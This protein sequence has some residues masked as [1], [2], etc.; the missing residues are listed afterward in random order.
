MVTASWIVLSVQLHDHGTWVSISVPGYR[1][2][3]FY[4]SPSSAF[5]GLGNLFC[6]TDN[7]LLSF[8]AIKNALFGLINIPNLVHVCSHLPFNL[9]LMQ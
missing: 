3:S 6:A 8:C 7:E 9:A 1:V 5:L 2:L 4:T